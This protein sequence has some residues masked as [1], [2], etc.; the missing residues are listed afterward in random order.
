MTTHF[1]SLLRAPGRLPA[2]FLFL[3]F[4]AL[5]ATAG[6]R[7]WGRNTG[8]IEGRVYNPASKEYVPNAEISLAGSAQRIYS[9]DNGG[10]RFFDVPAGR[11]E[12]TV[13]YSGY[14]TARASV[15]VI[16]GQTVECEISLIN[17][18]AGEPASKDGE[19]VVLERFVV[20]A[21]REGDARAIMEQRR[22]LN[23]ANSVS[24][25][26]YGD[27]PD[28]N[29]GEF[30]KHMPGVDLETNLH[31]DIVAARIGGM[32]PEYGA[33]TIDGM[34]IASA[35]ANDADVRA[36]NFEQYTI[37][38][39]E[40]IEVSKTIS[41][42][43]PASAPAGTIN[44]KPRRSFNRKGRQVV[45]QTSFTA[46]EGDWDLRKTHGPD[47]DKHF[48]V[49]PTVRLAYS[50]VFFN[51][52]LGVVLTLNQSSIYSSSGYTTLYYNYLATDPDPLVASHFTLYSEARIT[53]RLNASLAMD[54][55][56]TRNLTLSLS[57]I[58]N[59]TTL[60]STQ[61]NVVFETPGSG[62]SGRAKLTHGP[63]PMTSFSTTTGE[64]RVSPASVHKKGESYA[65]QPKFEWRLGRL[66]LDGRFSLSQSKSWYNPLSELGSVRQQ[67][68][69]TVSGVSYAAERSS[70]MD[71]DWKVTQTGG[72]DISEATGYS[73][74]GIGASQ[75]NIIVDD[76]R[77]ALTKMK[78]GDIQG[79]LTTR[80]P[81][82]IEWKA[83]ARVDQEERE[84][85]NTSDANV[86]AYTGPGSGTGA[87]AEYNSPFEFNTKATDAGITSI[88]G[89]NIFMPNLIGIGKL[90]LEHPG[91]FTQDLTNSRFENAYVNSNR[92][93]KE[94]VWAGFL[95]GTAQIHRLTVRAG[96]RWE[97]TWTEAREPDALTAQEVRD[98][99]YAISAGKATTIEGLQYQFLSRPFRTRKANYDHLFPSMVLK[100][101]IASN[102]DAQ[103]GYARTIRRPAPNH[104]AGTWIVRDDDTGHPNPYVTTGNINLKPEEAD[105]LAARIA[106]YFKPSGFLAL[107]LTQR[108]IR[109]LH[110]TTWLTAEEFG[111]TDPIY[112]D[113]D[114][115]TTSNVGSP[116][117]IRG[118]ELEC[119]QSLGFLLKGLRFRANYT[120]TYSAD[121]ILLGISPNTINAGLSYSRGRLS[122]NINTTWRDDTYTNNTD[123]TRWYRHRQTVDFDASLKL[124][125]YLT[126]S[127]AGRNITSEP[128]ILMGTTGTAPSPVITA[129]RQYAVTL[130]VWSFSLKAVF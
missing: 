63:D 106:Y 116:I 94:T 64:I 29:I 118:L 109:N 71:G 10:F 108:D 123:G 3:F 100:Y 86:Y 111:N 87:L 39:V 117:R 24:T 59:R 68:G 48:K 62:A 97:G 32:S 88:S 12:L 113:Y 96:L 102:L 13:F 54:F 80:W 31:G 53:D 84:Y 93:M 114:F 119:R 89:N 4:G 19:T 122:L 75:G 129:A 21:E 35:N 25:D 17:S 121:R 26:A 99:G 110:E 127:V 60:N 79:K 76:G 115:R 2:V 56:A 73:G 70:S 36:F 124:T 23:I 103:V 30:L 69:R 78:T 7:A 22:A 45:I 15:N 107:T 104:I 41:A 33:V 90:Y 44:L 98:A 55:K 34:S 9:D 58:T 50:D 112:E 20:S 85:R 14:N 74:G 128:R 82:P 92:D 42:D 120:R 47:D 95:M 52:R 72:P 101:N 8:T 16:A 91:W 11:A 77:R 28:G 66:Q 5:L 125:R 130:P 38:S 6:P 65:V 83:G 49:R 43:V 61:R 40:S 105:S 67:G 37:D 18:E 27:I 81:V 51:R 1:C 126:L 57:L 46:G